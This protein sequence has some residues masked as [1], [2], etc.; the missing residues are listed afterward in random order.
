MNTLGENVIRFLGHADSR[1]RDTDPSLRVLQHPH[2]HHDSDPRLVTPGSYGGTATEPRV[3]AWEFSC[4]M[5]ATQ[6][7]SDHVHTAGMFWV[8]VPG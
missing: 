4:V 8:I 7:R 3:I 6:L 5:Y 2:I 1:P